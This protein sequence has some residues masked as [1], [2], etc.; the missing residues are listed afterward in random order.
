MIHS[1][2]FT[3]VLDTNVI[4]PIEIRDVLFWFA[5]HELYTPKWS[6]HI[7]DEWR[8]VMIRKAITPEEAD[9]RIARA[10]QAFPDALVTNYDALIDTLTLPDE[11]DRHILAAAIKVNANLIITNNLKDFPPDYLAA[12]G[13][14]AK[15]ADDFLTDT[16]DLNPPIAVQ[17]FDDLV[18]NRKTPTS[19][20]LKSWRRYV[21]MG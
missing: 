6:R 8:E 13:L 12:F 7:F 14:A 18:F 19:I 9:K 3:C 5:F 16:I 10:N 1:V 20:I 2:H 17:A 21:E 11:K 4:Y 15:S